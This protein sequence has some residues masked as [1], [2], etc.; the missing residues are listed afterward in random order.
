MAGA[1]LSMIVQ[2]GL[3]PAEEAKADRLDGPLTELFVSKGRAV[4]LCHVRSVGGQR[5]IGFVDFNAGGQVA[6]IP[7]D[8]FVNLSDDEV[9]ARVR[10]QL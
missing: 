8:E 10:E 5:T 9:L 3:S 4:R 1:K 7:A 2:E 6:A